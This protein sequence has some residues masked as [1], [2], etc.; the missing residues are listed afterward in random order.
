MG[1]EAE[2]PPRKQ[3]KQGGVQTRWSVAD[4]AGATHVL[5][6]YRAEIDE[7][8][9]AYGCVQYGDLVCWAFG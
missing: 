1:S 6:K 9:L 5:E 4:I 7:K 2:E 3:P 8:R